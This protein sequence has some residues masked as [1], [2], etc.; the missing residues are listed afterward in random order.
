MITRCTEFDVAIKNGVD[1]FG[2][3]QYV[4]YY[5]SSTGRKAISAEQPSNIVAEV[6]AVWGDAPTMPNPEPLPLPDHTPPT[7]TIEQRLAALEAVQL[8]QILGGAV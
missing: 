7:P 1:N 3:V 8:E 4:T 5:N 2:N 6:M